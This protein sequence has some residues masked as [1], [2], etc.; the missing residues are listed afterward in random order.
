MFTPTMQ[1][2][3]KVD[4]ACSHCAGNARRACSGRGGAIPR[5]RGP[6]R[7]YTPVQEAAEVLYPGPGGRGGATPRSRRPQR[8]YTLVRAASTRP[9]VAAFLIDSCRAAADLAGL[10][11]SS[12]GGPRQVRWRNTLS[13]Q[14]TP[15][16][17]IVLRRGAAR[18]QPGKASSQVCDIMWRLKLSRPLTGIGKL[19][20]REGDT[21][22]CEIARGFRL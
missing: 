5:S 13:L 10:A 3:A 21:D 16:E 1:P 15:R 2:I 18:C 20:T 6:G 12:R 14:I 17:L 8:C 22:S 11:E 4:I 9:V 19:E 7:C